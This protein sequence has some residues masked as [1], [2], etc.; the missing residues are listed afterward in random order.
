MRW[1][2]PQTEIL[3]QSEMSIKK[4]EQPWCRREFLPPTFTG[5]QGNLLSVPSS[6][7][8]Y[9]FSSRLFQT[10]SPFPMLSSS[11]LE[12]RAFCASKNTQ[13]MFA[14][15]LNFTYQPTNIVS[16]SIFPIAIE[17][18]SLSVPGRACHQGSPLYTLHPPDYLDTAASP[19]CPSHLL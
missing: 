5:P 15:F 9:S 2:Y 10:L 19:T 3:A 12:A 4:I 11:S 16:P 6:I 7:F 17:Q 14:S 8:S 1:L 18:S 13:L